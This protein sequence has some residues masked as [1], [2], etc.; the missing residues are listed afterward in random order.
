[1]SYVIKNL[2]NYLAQRIELVNYATTILGDRSRGEDVVQ[3]AFLRLTTTAADRAVEEPIG[4]LRRI[5]RNLSLDVIR[6]ISLERKYFNSA[7]PTETIIEDRPSQEATLAHRQELLIVL[8]A[9]DELPERT[10]IALE[11]YRF[12]EKK[13]KDI[14]IHLGISIALTHSLIFAGV[15]HCKKRLAERS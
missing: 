1:M 3:E 12:D 10:R 2:D 11:M 4:Y 8:K 7:V 15:E 13:L 14:A 9:M 5:V 6:R